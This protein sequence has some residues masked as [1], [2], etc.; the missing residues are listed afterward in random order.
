MQRSGVRL[1]TDLS[2]IVNCLQKDDP[3]YRLM[4]RELEIFRG[5][6]SQ[7]HNCMNSVNETLQ[8]PDF[9]SEP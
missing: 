4:K 9:T 1:M 6:L 7:F 5:I 8:P 3:R 2:E